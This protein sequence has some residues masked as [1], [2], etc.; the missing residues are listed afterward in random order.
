MTILAPELRSQFL[1]L[2][3]TKCLPY[4]EAQ[5]IFKRQQ[6]KLAYVVVGSVATGLCTRTSDIDVAIVGDAA[7]YEE[8]TKDPAWPT[9]FTQEQPAVGDRPPGGDWPCQTMVDGVPLQFYCTT[10]EWIQGGLQDLRDTYIYHYGT[11][12]VL[13]DAGERYGQLLGA[14][15][16]AAP[17]FRRQRLEGKLDLLRRRY[18]AL[19]ASLR[20]LDIMAATQTGLEMITLAV[21]VTALLDDVPFD[22]RKRLFFTGLAGRLGY[23]LENS[24][25]QM[26]M[27]LGEFGQLQTGTN[28]AGLRLPSRLVS[29]INVLSDEAREQGFKVGLDRP[30]P[31][32]AE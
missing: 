2:A 31:R 4:L 8:L 17:E 1:E 6:G 24:F 16:S 18:A 32:C 11:A 10:F 5:T 3:K 14:L 21:K 30:D 29:V 12:V 13:Q 20:Y 22:P 26:V 23:Q 25:R 9:T 28:L 7:T 15:R 27:A 19:E